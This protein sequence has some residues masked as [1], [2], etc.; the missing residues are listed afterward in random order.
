MR[1]KH[2]ASLDRIAE[3]LLAAKGVILFTHHQVDG[4]C[5]GSALAICS[6]LKRLGK[7]A[8]VLMKDK[9][10]DYLAFL[11]EGDVWTANGDLDEMERIREKAKKLAERL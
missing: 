3:R 2:Y 8:V 6:A 7:K 9:V 4:D 11:N 10:P 1:C 5:L